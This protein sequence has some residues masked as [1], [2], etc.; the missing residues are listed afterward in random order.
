MG[1]SASNDKVW[2][3]EVRVD[4]KGTMGMLKGCYM[5]LCLKSGFMKNE[6]APY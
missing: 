1:F 3:V 5:I 4:A 2:V 6:I